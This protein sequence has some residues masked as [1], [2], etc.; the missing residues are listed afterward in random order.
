[1]IAD[2]VE[3]ATRSLSERKWLEAPMWRT[4]SGP[5]SSASSVTTAPIPSALKLAP[6]AT[7]QFR[8]PEHTPVSYARVSPKLGVV[9]ET[10]RDKL[11]RIPPLVPA[12]VKETPG[13]RFLFC[14]F[15]DFGDFALQFTLVYFVTLE[16]G[17]NYLETVGAVNY[18]IHAAFEQ[19]GISFAYPTQTVVMRREGQG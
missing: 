14:V 13:T 10:P 9:Y 4:C 11:E 8:R 1:M 18:R 19:E 12:C 2:S 7:G 6:L 3:A 17:A 5:P 16:A 15:T